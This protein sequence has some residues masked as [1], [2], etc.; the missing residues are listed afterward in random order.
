MAEVLL[1]KY[2]REQNLKI[3]REFVEVETAKVTGRP[4]FKEMLDFLKNS[5]DCRLILVEKTDRLYRNFQD[6]VDLDELGVDI[7]FT[8]E[9]AIVGPNAR[10]SDKFMHGIR[11]LMAKNYVDNLSEEVKKGLQEKVLRGEWPHG[12]PWGYRNNKE[13][14]LIEPDA[15]KSVIVKWLYRRYS[16]GD[17]SVK[18]LHGEY[19]ALD[20]GIVLGLSY[21]KKIL[22][23]PFYKGQMLWKGTVYPAIHEPLIDIPTWETVQLILSASSKPPYAR[24][25]NV[26]TYQ[27]LIKCDYCGCSIVPEIKKGRYIYYHCTEKRG[28]CK[29]NGWVRQ[30]LLDEQFLAEIR[31]SKLDDQDF[32]HRMEVLQSLMVQ[33]KADIVQEDKDLKVRIKALQSEL[34]LLYRQQRGHQ[35]HRFVIKD[36]HDVILEK[37][38]NLT[39]RLKEVQAPSTSRYT[40]YEKLL[41]FSNRA[42]KLFFNGTI[43]IRRKVVETLFEWVMM[44]DG[45]IEVSPKIEPFTDDILTSLESGPQ[46]S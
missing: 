46:F 33:E 22:S 41:D 4:R 10:S 6:M 29:E 11:V 36:Q 40:E 28:A 13:L 32:T 38:S 45:K 19:M 3:V 9:G 17:I 44:Y 26:F 37:L 25:I 27:K 30:E 14:G 42:D 43:E 23:N 31:K 39:E 16:V 24:K 12:A 20:N 18:R 8:K 2:A 34:E 35:N 1:R 5:S 7:Y 15:V 21:I